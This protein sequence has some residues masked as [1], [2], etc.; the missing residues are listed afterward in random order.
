MDQLAS[1]CGRAGHALLIDCRTLAVTHVRVPE[2]I[3]VLVVH[4]GLSRTLERSEY[5]ARRAE[6]ERIAAELGLRALRDATPE[7]V[8]HEPLARHVVSEN[9]RVHATA[10]ALE[11]GDLA[12]VGELFLA[13]HASLRDDYRVSTDELDALV[14]E[15]VGAGAAGARLTGAGFGGCVVGVAEANAAAAI[16]ER[17]T[18]GYAAATGRAPTAWICAPAGGAGS[19]Q[20]P[21]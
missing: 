9:A 10:A 21:P 6:C 18:A 3:A 17:A 16:L 1:V 15:L 20:P 11:R 14:E 12:Q 19:I 8:E 5:A 4:S 2:A 13:S 7:Q